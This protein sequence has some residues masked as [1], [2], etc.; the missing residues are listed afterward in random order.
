[1]KKGL[2]ERQLARIARFRNL[3]DGEY[4][5]HIGEP[6]DS[7][8][9]KE[10]C[11]QVAVQTARGEAVAPLAYGSALAGFM[12]AHAAVVEDDGHRRFRMDVLS[13]LTTPQRTS[14]RPRVGCPYC[15]RAAY[16]RVYAE[17]WASSTDA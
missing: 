6:I 14:P 7:F 2:N 5:A 8:Y 1:M 12:L 16:R 4:A 17:R 3:A 10:F 11:A 15:A 13:G 9:N